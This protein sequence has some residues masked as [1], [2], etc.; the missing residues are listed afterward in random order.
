MVLADVQ[1]AWFFK[2]TGASLPLLDLRRQ[3]LD[4]PAHQV[5]YSNLTDHADAQMVWYVKETDV[6][7]QLQD[8]LKQ[9]LHRPDARQIL[10][11]NL[12]DPVDVQTV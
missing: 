11:D 10:C 6:L 7:P 1:T 3:H 4:L 9:L 2:E 12:M 5:W 8:H